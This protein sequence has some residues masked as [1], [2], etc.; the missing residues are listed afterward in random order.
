MGEG[1]EFFAF[2]GALQTLPEVLAGLP[3]PSYLIFAGMCFLGGIISGAQGTIALSVPLAFAAIPDGG[4]P[5]VV[6]LMGMAHAASQISPTHVCLVV[7]AEYYHVSL[8][9]LIRKTLPRALLFCVLMVGYY[10]LLQLLI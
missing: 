4:I 1:K 5:L 2:T 8:G 10:H 9:E 7:A 6:R 3:I